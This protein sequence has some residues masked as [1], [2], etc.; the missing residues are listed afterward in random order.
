MKFQ[1]GYWKEGDHNMLNMIA[2][3]LV[4]QGKI[5]GFKFPS[6]ELG[7]NFETEKLNKSEIVLQQMEIIKT[8]S[9]ENLKLINDEITKISTRNESLEG[10]VHPETGV[11]F[12]KKTVE[13]NGEKIEVVV[14]EFKSVYDIQ[15]PDELCEASDRNQFDECN[16]QLKDAIEKDPELKKKFTDEQLQQIMDG[17]TPDG[18]TWHHDVEKGKMQL[19]DS[20][21]HAKT[22]HTGGKSIWGGGSDNR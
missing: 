19:V 18:F 10:S 7:K 15:L 20:E 6:S 13:I 21:T 4:E 2:K 14:P 17:E 8:T 1:A 16:R 22:G 9:L 11:P 3:A 5:E 12:V